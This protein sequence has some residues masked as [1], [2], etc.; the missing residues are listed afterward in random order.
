MYLPQIIY[1]M[2][3]KNGEEMSRYSLEAEMSWAEISWGDMSMG[4][5]SGYHIVQQTELQRMNER[6]FCTYRINPRHSQKGLC[7]AWIKMYNSGKRR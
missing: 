3:A 4:K 5:L 1:A 2:S 7:R 6:D